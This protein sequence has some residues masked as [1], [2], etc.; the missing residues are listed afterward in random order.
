M[1]LLKITLIVS[2]FV[3]CC[4]AKN[5]VL[6]KYTDQIN[7]YDPKMN[8]N[9]NVQ[10]VNLKCEQIK[11]GHMYYEA[12]YF[13]E[14]GVPAITPVMIDVEGADV[15]GAIIEIM[16]EYA[17]FFTYNAIEKS[18]VAIKFLPLLIQSRNYILVNIVATL[19]NERA[20]A[21]LIISMPTKECV[22]FYK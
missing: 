12:T 6:D 20:E 11:F 4:K 1:W 18:I 13:E 5:F 3:F 7:I 16:G 19:G 9:E 22:N 15:S 10:G 17:D 2:L 21:L 8:D 14:D